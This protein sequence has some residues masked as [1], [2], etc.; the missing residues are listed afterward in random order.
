MFTAIVAVSYEETMETVISDERG[1]KPK[2]IIKT[3]EC[4]LQR[5]F[6]EIAPTTE[7]KGTTLMQI[8]F[9]ISKMPLS[10]RIFNKI[11]RFNFSPDI[12]K[13]ENKKEKEKN[14]ENEG[15]SIS[16]SEPKLPSQVNPMIDRFLKNTNAVNNVEEVIE[17]D[18]ELNEIEKGQ[19]ALWMTMLESILKYKSNNEMEV[20]DLVRKSYDRE[21]TIEFY[22]KRTVDDLQPHVKD[23]VYSSR[24]SMKQKRAWK[25][26][27][28][29]KKYEYWCGMDVIHSEYYNKGKQAQ[30]EEEKV[31]VK[32]LSNEDD[33]GRT[34][35]VEIKD[36]SRKEEKNKRNEKLEESN[37]RQALAS[38]DKNDKPNES[39]IDGDNSKKEENS[40]I[41]VKKESEKMKTIGEDIEETK[42]LGV[43]N[44]EVSE[45][46]ISIEIA[47]GTP[48]IPREGDLTLKGMIS[49][50]EYTSNYAKCISSIQ[51]EYWKT[52]TITEK[53][54]FWLFH[55]TGKQR[56]KL[57]ICM[58][59][60]QK[61]IQEYVNAQI[62]CITKQE[63]NLHDV[64][65]YL[66]QKSGTS[67]EEIR[68]GEDG[69]S[70]SD[71]TMTHKIALTKS[72]WCAN[73][74]NVV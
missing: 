69:W 30:R 57:W 71:F 11:L 16:C 51:F 38:E 28:L 6:N 46:M 60:S 4:E 32:Q 74:R 21:I 12:I 73:S 42:S 47:N 63:P 5:K 8:N 72:K 62:P 26:A 61:V 59:F 39:K 19:V 37:S 29:V 56:V 20:F 9:I 67:D 44:D 64:W 2:G 70:E 10:Y 68:Q 15:S 24:M 7:R 31:L 17:K 35:I 45:S 33:G 22:P 65:S 13:R 55:L 58:K 41:L 48:L 53:I 43:S 49:S 14:E 25:E 52:L 66:N 34:R 1:E 36:D 54:E 50:P 3:I 27:D 23:F 18:K 40:S